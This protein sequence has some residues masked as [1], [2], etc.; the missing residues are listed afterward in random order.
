M[1]TGL[2]LNVIGDGV[3]AE[4]TFIARTGTPG[5]DY[6]IDLTGACLID[7][8]MESKWRQLRIHGTLTVEE[9]PLPLERVVG[10]ARWR[11]RGSERGA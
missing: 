3:L 10:F 6:T 4:L 11:S 7:A 2:N 1:V 5:G 9:L 8:H